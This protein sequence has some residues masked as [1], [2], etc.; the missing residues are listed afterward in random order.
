MS[1]LQTDN[2]YWFSVAAQNEVG[3]SN[4]S[5]TSDSS[6]CTVSG[7]S[8]GELAVPTYLWTLHF[9]GLSFCGLWS[10]GVVFVLWI[11]TPIAYCIIRMT[12]VK[13]NAVLFHFPDILSAAL[14]AWQSNDGVPP[15]RTCPSSFDLHF[16]TVKVFFMVC[17]ESCYWL[18]LAVIPSEV[19][20]RNCLL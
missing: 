10:F 6:G 20:M 11:S 4:A 12:V 2:C 8:S 16:A 14:R 3:T 19:D 13:L 15:L 1:G 9:A 18:A 7:L 5:R 17:W